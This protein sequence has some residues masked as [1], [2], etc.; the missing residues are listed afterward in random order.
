MKKAFLAFAQTLI[1]TFCFAQDIIIKVNGEEIKSKIL[2]VNQ[3][4]IKY[5]V[6]DYQSGPSYTVSKSEIFMIRYENGSKDIFNNAKEKKDSIVSVMPSEEMR[7]KAKQDAITYYL[8]KNS[9]AAWTMATT[10][11]T[12]PILGLI[13]AFACAA[14]EPNEDNLNAPDEKLMKN[15]DYN[16]AY[17]DQSRKIKKRKI[18]KNFAIGSGVWVGL[19][20]IGGL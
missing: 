9:G 2:E 7:T 17:V 12:S 20:L 14:S 1:V 4:E 16:K 3:G 13:P 15:A 19:V 6:F 10:I 8:G 11:V 18:W 5:K